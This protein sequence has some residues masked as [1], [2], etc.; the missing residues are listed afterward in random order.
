VFA[1]APTLVQAARARPPAVR[2]A[3]LLAFVVPIHV[4]SI[5]VTGTNPRLA[6]NLS[7]WPTLTLFGFLLFGLVI[8]VIHLAA[9][10][11]LALRERL[12]GRVGAATAPLLA[13][14][15]ALALRGVP[16]E[17]YGAVRLAALAVP[18]ALLAALAGRRGA[19]P[20]VAFLVAG[21]LV[22]G[23]IKLGQWHAE[24]FLAEARDAVAP[25]VIAA[26]ERYRAKHDFHPSSLE[27]LVPEEL[28]AIPTPRIGWLGSDD[29]VFTYTDLGDSFLLEFPGPVW[30]QCAYSP[31]YEE[32]PEEGEE[33]GAGEPPAE[34]L[35]AAW[36]CESKP[37]RLW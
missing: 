14:A 10:I 15:V 27:E 11:G 12:P 30:V 32:E 21:L 29:E 35:A 18:A 7:P 2:V 22:L 9:G 20:S 4:L 31:P 34:G 6:W 8:G 36:S 17:R 13:A 33:V 3:A 16:F 19:R 26:L 23:S 28:P 25:E 37:P 1:L 5:E 24:R